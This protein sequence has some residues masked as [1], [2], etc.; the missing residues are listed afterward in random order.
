VFH[1][2]YPILIVRRHIGMASITFNMPG[3]RMV[4]YSK[5]HIKPVLFGSVV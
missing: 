5:F 1:G 3:T 4:P 2:H